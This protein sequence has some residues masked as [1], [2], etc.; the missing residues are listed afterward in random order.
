MNIDEMKIKRS[1][2]LQR[3]EEI[4]GMKSDELTDEL[5]T[6]FD[7]LEGKVNV[8]NKDIERAERAEELAAKYI[9]TSSERGTVE[10]TVE[11]KD[12]IEEATKALRS[13]L[14]TGEAPEEYRSERGGFLVPEYLFR[15]D[16]LVT[17]TDSGIIQKQVMA[18]LLV[19]KSPAESMLRD[20][21]VK[22]Y[23]GLNGNFVIPSMPQV[24]ASF[25]AETAQADSADASPTSLTLT[26]RRVPVSQKFTKEL[27]AQTNPA[28]YTGIVQDLQ[29][30]IWRAVADD[31]FTQ[32]EADAIDCSTSL[33]G[34]TLAYE[35]MV[36]LQAAVPYELV[37]PAYVS[38]TAVAAYLKK[39]PTLANITGP[40]WE[41][42][43]LRGNV[44]GIKAIGTNYAVGNS[45]Y[46]G[47]FSKA[48]IG[49]WGTI[50]LLVNPYTLAK[51]GEIEVVATGLFDS[52]V[53]NCKFFSWV[54]N[55]AL[56]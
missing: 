32:F 33:A 48:A 10:E 22:M 54:K 47:D 12:Q 45:V 2:Y 28:I 44:D 26:A 42:P 29:D 9:Q 56:S 52:G 15:A 18:G 50:E 55:A 21:G 7:D 24:S 34:S 40:V 8:I 41:G 37:N 23:T 13:Y 46:Y 35:D 51:E 14:S 11:E 53:P 25:K 3:L 4:T 49:Q 27:L 36:N 39:T 43:I 5:R 30:A 20:L 31:F 17:T 6:E 1:E 19:A 38:S 16:P